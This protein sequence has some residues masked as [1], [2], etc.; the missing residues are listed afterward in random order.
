MAVL[1]D[2]PYVQFNFLVDLGTGSTDQ[3]IEIGDVLS[4]FDPRTRA[5]LRATLDG[6]ARGTAGR[7][8]DLARTLTYSGTALSDT[9]DLVRQ[10]NSDGD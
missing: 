8:A 5:A 7:G 2:R 1:R 9:S 10:V 3:P 4:T 6:L